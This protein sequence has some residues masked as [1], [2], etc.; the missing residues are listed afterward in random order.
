MIGT[1]AFVLTLCCAFGGQTI[2]TVERADQA[3]CEKVRKIAIKML[4]DG[5]MRYVATECRDTS[6]LRG[7][8]P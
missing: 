4:D 8:Q 7:D 6:R 5:S 1:W 3:T 2:V